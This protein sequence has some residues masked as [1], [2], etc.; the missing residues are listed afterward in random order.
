MNTEKKISNFE[1]YQTKFWDE[2]TL[3]KVDPEMFSFWVN[4]I[5]AMKQV[6]FDICGLMQSQ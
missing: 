5:F 2:Y 1:E 3:K 6:L 4:N